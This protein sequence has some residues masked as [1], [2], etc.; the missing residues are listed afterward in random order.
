MTIDLITIVHRWQVPARD[1]RQLPISGHRARPARP[2]VTPIGHGYSRQH[3]NRKRVD[4]SRL[5]YPNRPLTGM[6]GHT[7]ARSGC[8]TYAL[9]VRLKGSAPV[10]QRA[11]VQVT[12][13]RG[14]RRTHTDAYEL[15]P[16]LRPLDETDSILANDVNGDLAGG[17][18][19]VA[20]RRSRWINRDGAVSRQ[21][22][23]AGSRSPAL[24]DAKIP[25]AARLSVTW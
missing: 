11:F 5:D 9:R 18:G 22:G 1:G 7:Q 24:S 2:R 4:E 19:G 15:R 21:A 13:L 17:D 10:H 20:S 8:S 6:R 23:S 12:A 25:H 3:P 14:L 16:K